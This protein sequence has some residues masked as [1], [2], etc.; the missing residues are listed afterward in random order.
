MYCWNVNW[1][2]RLYQWTES[3][4]NEYFL[5][6]CAAGLFHWTVKYAVAVH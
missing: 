6:Q 4:D 2:Y 3:G 5:E 1:I